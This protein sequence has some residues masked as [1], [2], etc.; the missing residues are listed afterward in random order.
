MSFTPRLVLFDWVGALGGVPAQPG[1][2]TVPAAAQN[3]LVTTWS[4]AA[5]VVRDPPVEKS[6]FYRALEEEEDGEEEEEKGGGGVR[7][8]GAQE[9]DAPHK[10]PGDEAPAASGC[11]PVLAEA[12]DAL[13]GSVRYWSD[14]SKAV[15]HPRS[16]VLYPAPWGIDTPDGYGATHEFTD[17]TAAEEAH[18]RIRCAALV[19]MQGASCS[20]HSPLHVHTPGTL[21]RSVTPWPASTSWCTTA[22]PSGRSQ[23]RC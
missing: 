4:S 22:A 7:D 16:M 23:R 6:R 14:Y 1:A 11:G 15:L 2:L 8:A 20:L 3:V 9:G 5:R 13:E 18:E 21:R 19:E 12:A 17:G 10:Q